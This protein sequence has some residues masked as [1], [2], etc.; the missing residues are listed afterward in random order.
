MKHA[1]GSP[2]YPL[3][4]EP[5]FTLL[6]LGIPYFE[7]S[8]RSFGQNSENFPCQAG[9]YPQKELLRAIHTSI[10]QL[11][12]HHIYCIAMESYSCMKD[13]RFVTKA[14]FWKTPSWSHYKTFIESIHA[15]FFISWVP[16]WEW[17]LQ[18][19]PS[20]QRRWW[21]HTIQVST[22]QR[23]KGLVTSWIRYSMRETWCRWSDLGNSMHW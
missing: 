7:R 16:G 6:I 9:L 17:S 5:F 4:F 8:F 21:A 23:S 1:K 10:P 13:V 15:Y 18:L 2:L 11:A 12:L 3:N 14:S 20:R 22:I 19:I